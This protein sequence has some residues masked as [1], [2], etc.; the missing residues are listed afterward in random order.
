MT[1]D[2][3]EFLINRK[4]LRLTIYA[5]LAIANVIFGLTHP[6]HALIAGCGFAFF[7]LLTLLQLRSQSRKNTSST[8]NIPLQ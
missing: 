3:P 1:A 2:S 4:T 8:K 6:E 7:I 5:S